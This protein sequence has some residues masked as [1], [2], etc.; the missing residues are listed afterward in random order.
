LAACSGF[1]TRP[2]AIDAFVAGD[3]HYY[4]WNNKPLDNTNNSNDPIYAMDPI[5]REQL[6]Q[7]LQSKGYSLDPQKAEFTVDYVYAERLRLGERSG[8]VSNLG[9]MPGAIPNR[10]LDQ[11][12]IDNAYALGGVKETS[13]IGILFRDIESNAEVW[14][15][16]ITKII[17]NTNLNEQSHIQ[18]K[19]KKAIK[20]GLKDLPHSS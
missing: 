17:E 19:V 2:S 14:R 13:N 3:Y 1:E 20:L 12:S 5:L 11:A 9:T 15:V 4:R 6:T 16:V 8:D 18:R 10:N 7:E